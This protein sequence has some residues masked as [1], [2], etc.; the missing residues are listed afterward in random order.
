V[1]D[2]S[3]ATMLRTTLRHEVLK[4]TVKNILR[5]KS[6]NEIPF[7]FFVKTYGNLGYAYNK[8]PGNNYMNNQL[9]STAGFGLDILTIYDL[10][11]KL[12][13]SYNQFGEKGF[14]IH[15]ATDF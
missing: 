14:F 9:L 2:G 11:L 3:L 12:E 8:N 15:T 10:V 13:Y 4:F 6:H 5:S 1:A 7:R